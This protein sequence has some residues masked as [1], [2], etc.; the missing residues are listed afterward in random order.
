MEG[1]GKLNTVVFATGATVVTV[2]PFEVRF[3]ATPC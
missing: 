2:V 3:K 1:V